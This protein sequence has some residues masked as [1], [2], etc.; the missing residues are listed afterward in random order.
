MRSRELYSMSIKWWNPLHHLFIK[1]GIE[2][3]KRR[4]HGEGTIYERWTA[5][6]TDPETGKSKQ[7]CARSKNNL[8]EK[9]SK[10]NIDING[11]SISQSWIA[12]ATI[13]RNYETG[14]PIRVTYYGKT[15]KEVQDKLSKVLHDVKNGV[16]VTPSKITFAEWLDTWLNEY[17]KPQLRPTTYADYYRWI[18]NHI[19]PGL[20]GILLKDLQPSH[21][22]KF[23]NQKLH[24]PKMDRRSEETKKKNP[25]KMISPLSARSVR[26]LH[27]L[28]RESLQ[29]ALKENLIT[30]N[31]ADA[32]R[33]PKITKKE[34]AFLTADQI[35]VFLKS[36]SEDRWYAAFVTV[37]GTGLRLGELAALRWEN[38]DLKKGIIHVKEAVSRVETFEPEGPKT[39]LII[40][41]PKTKK[42][43]RSIPLPAFV[44]E[45]LKR[46]KT[47]QTEEKILLGTAWQAKL[48]EEMGENYKDPG[49]LFTWQD[50]R[51]VDPDYLSKH[52]RKL[53]KK[54]NIE[55]IHF[56]SLRHSY[57]SLLLS[58][59]VHPKIV[60]ENLGHSTISMT[61]DTYSHVAPGLKEA[62]AKSLDGLFQSKQ[63]EIH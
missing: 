25:N 50:G 17:A 37:L 7:I 43:L 9:L 22:Q 16:F 38:V 31:P 48:R 30:R 19:K 54:A 45:E 15:R 1:G 24:E 61:L 26:Y 44:I 51:P 27:V 47:R 35:S 62:A 52:F 39:K 4:G 12:Q 53:I 60:Q 14:K 8:L 28:I 13:G 57:A 59:N 55:G 56:H 10:L 58:N 46:L 41:P 63:I 11:V 6:I 36:I 5:N 3:A 34:A 33:P 32:T 42:G 49:F 23:Y 2:M 21:I 18:K 40:Q 20:G 29:Q